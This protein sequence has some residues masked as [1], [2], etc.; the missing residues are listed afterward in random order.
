MSVYTR[1]AQDAILDQ[2]LDLCKGLEQVE[3]RLSASAE[4]LSRFA[5]N[6]IQ[7]N[8]SQQDASLH[9]SLVE[10]G[11]Q[12]F[13][14]TNRLDST[15][16]A[17]LVDTARRIASFQEP[18]RD[19]LPLVAS[20]PTPEKDCLDPATASW[21][22]EDKAALLARTFELARESGME[23]SGILSNSW[24]QLALANSAGLRC[25][26][27]GSR[28]R[29]STTYHGHNA[30]GWS[31][32]EARGHAGL[33]VEAL[34]LEALRIAKAAANPQQ[35]EPGA[36]TVV[37]PPAAVADLLMFLNWLGLGAQD[38][39][40]GTSPMADKT[41]KA[42]FSP[43]FSLS[44]DAAHPLTDG[45]P[46]D[47]DGLSRRTV[48]LVDQ[49]VFLGPVHDRITA[50]QAG[51]ESTGHAL[52]RPNAHGPF[53]GNL[54]VAPGETTLDELVAGT[55]RGLFVTHL[56]YT[57]VQDRNELLLTGMTRDGLFLIENGNITRP[58]RNMRFTE[59]LFRA[60]ANIEAVSCDQAFHGG[61]FGGGFV[62]PGL[63]IR[64]F[65]FTSE[66]GF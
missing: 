36:W 51:V 58:V 64:D 41:G 59:S 17:A 6:G 60:F 26:Y 14:V 56:H 31:E 37:L 53:P 22:P 65:H 52:P 10:G 8:L 19:L 54:V 20:C 29:F 4:A 11:R 46:F 63:K 3:L 39:L 61:F 47:F 32:G 44:D 35:P 2:T 57:N 28:A 50:R 27:Q 13:A 7:Q 9:I 25:R 23:A 1:E 62:L 66:S 16:L 34:S 30:S 18:A 40:A 12:G 42:L 55:Q 38:H 45:M 15:G 21:G 48:K 5:N 33:D 49:G 24:S 43:L